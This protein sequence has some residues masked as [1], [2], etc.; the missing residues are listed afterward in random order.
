MK[1]K[2]AELL[3][4]EMTRETCV[5][6]NVGALFFNSNSAKSVGTY[7]KAKRALDLSEPHLGKGDCSEC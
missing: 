4:T 5:L 3:L 2:V 1:E 7:K 6:W